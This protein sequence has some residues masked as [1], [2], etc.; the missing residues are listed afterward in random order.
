MAA[1]LG[2]DAAEDGLAGQAPIRVLSS[3]EIH[4][5][6]IKGLGVLGIGRGALRKVAARDGAIDLTRSPRRK[7]RSSW[8]ATPSR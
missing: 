5:S 1:R 8:S 7:R 4:A 6:A 2:F 3:T